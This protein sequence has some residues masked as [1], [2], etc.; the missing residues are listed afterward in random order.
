MHLLVKIFLEIA[1]CLIYTFETERK[2][3]MKKVLLTGATGL[4]GKELIKPL[5]ENNYEIFAISRK[6]LQNINNITWLIGDLF[7]SQFIKYCCEKARADILVHL[8]WKVTKDYAN[9]NE[10]FSF[11]ANSIS[12]LQEFQH[13]GGKQVFFCGSYFEYE[14]SQEK[15]SE[16]SPLAPEKMTYTFCKDELRKIAENFCRQNT[17]DFCYGRL[18][19]VFGHNEEKNRLTRQ[20]LDNL[21]ADREVVIKSGPLQKDYMYSREIANAIAAVIKNN[22]QGSINICTGKPI[23]I[24]D[25]ALTIA[26]KL[27]KEHLVNFH[28]DFGSQPLCIY[29]DNTKLLTETDYR[30]H[31]TFEQAIDEIIETY[32]KK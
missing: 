28:D 2:I 26:R 30:P 31:Y 4:I 3:I 18:F 10:N 32:N 19:N 25:I 27:H 16:Q 20:I 21:F 6:P 12:L 7:D 9:S 22:V 14:F 11:L 29:G 13:N 1:F 8:A 17:M 24:K 5:L 23:A 15:L